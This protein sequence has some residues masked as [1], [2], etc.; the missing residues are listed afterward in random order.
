MRPK[1]IKTVIWVGEKQWASLRTLADRL[2]RTAAQL[3]R[4]AI[5]L[6]LKKSAARRPSAEGGA[7]D[8]QPH[9]NS[10]RGASTATLLHCKVVSLS[11]YPFNRIRGSDY[12]NDVLA[13]L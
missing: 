6:L 13:L 10:I 11:I 2:D 3:V 1:K 5:V 12:I 8:Q 7:G 4:E 9:P